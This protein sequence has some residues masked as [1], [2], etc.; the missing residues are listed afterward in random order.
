MNDE[1]PI[2]K[3]LRRYAQKRRDEAG[4][5]AEL[6]PANRR[7]LQAEVTQQYPQVQRR[8]GWWAGLSL[9]MSRKL[10]YAVAAVAVIGVSA[11]IVRSPKSQPVG[12]A[13]LDKTTETKEDLFYEKDASVP[14]PV[15]IITEAKDSLALESKAAPLAKAVGTE[16]IAEGETRMASEFSPSAAQS[17]ALATSINSRSRNDQELKNEDQTATRREQVADSV[18]SFNDQYGGRSTDRPAETSTSPALPTL[19]AQST[20]QRSAPGTASP[21]QSRNG[22]FGGGGGRGGNA[23][24][25]NVAQRYSQAPTNSREYRSN[26]TTADTSPVLLNFV[27]E[28]SGDDI[29]VID[30]DNSTYV[31]KLQVTAADTAG[32][33]TQVAR[34]RGMVEAQRAATPA[35]TM[36]SEAEVSRGQNYSFQLIGT[37]RTLN[38]QVNF[39]GNFV[40]LT[41]PDSGSIA[42]AQFAE[43]AKEVQD[44]KL[45][46]PPLE[47]SAIQGRLQIG[48]R[49]EIELN[50]TP[51]PR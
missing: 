2:E 8:G 38:Q 11:L 51:V 14:A 28:Q 4:A 9:L 21:A 3:L 47:N 29:K 16:P 44:L 35:A 43:K 31:G 10:A 5:P 30:S 39:V 37:N 20:A 7:A 41:N 45:I 33:Q 42:T 34:D 46:L 26:R 6:H 22:G 23:G 12:L 50:A 17:P 1:R 15:T 18:A 24:P 49:R 40:N 25:A 32:A 36:A 19:A 13:A 48:T 27:V